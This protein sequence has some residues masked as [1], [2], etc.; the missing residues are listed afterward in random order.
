MSYS[1][2]G[3]FWFSDNASGVSDL[4]DGNGQI[5]PLVVAIPPSTG[6]G[7]GAPTGTVFN[8]GAGFVVSKNGVSGE[9][10]FLFAAEDGTISGWAPD[11]DMTNTIIAVNNSS[12]GAVYKG[13]ALTTDAAGHSFLYAAD[14]S[15]GTVDVFDQNFQPIHRAGAFEDAAIPSDYAA[16]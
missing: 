1:P 7:A 2:T 9:S 12:N 8:G 15:H 16:V 6:T 10:Q 4:L 13:L 3:P 5:I 11:I 14:F